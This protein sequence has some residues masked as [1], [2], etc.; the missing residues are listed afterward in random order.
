MNTIG[1]SQ[2]IGLSKSK[3]GGQNVTL[4]VLFM[5]DNS[6]ICIFWQS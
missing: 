5:K 1:L 3:Y 2:I 6:V 4:H